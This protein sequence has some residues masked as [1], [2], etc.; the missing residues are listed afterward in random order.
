VA[1]C[2]RAAPPPSVTPQIDGTTRG[3]YPL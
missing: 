2:Q 1:A 3:D